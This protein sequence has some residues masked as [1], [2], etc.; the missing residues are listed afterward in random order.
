M[1][2]NHLTC[3]ITVLFVFKNKMVGTRCI[4]SGCGNVYR[5]DKHVSFHEFPSDQSASHKW[6]QLLE[7]KGLISHDFRISAKSRICSEHFT[8]ECYVSGGKRMRLRKSAMPSLFLSEN[9]ESS[10]SDHTKRKR[11][12]NCSMFCAVIHFYI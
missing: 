11:P 10:I 1:R 7:E 12:G 2:G 9:F 4:I 3:L 6:I 8:N 5:R